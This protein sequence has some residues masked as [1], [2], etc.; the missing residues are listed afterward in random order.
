[1]TD[2]SGSMTFSYD[3]KGRLVEK[4]SIINRQSYTVSQSFTPGSRI[5]SVTYPTGRT[6]DYDRT[7]C[8]YIVDAVSTT[9]NGNTI[10]LANNLSYRPFGIANGINKGNG[11]MVNN[12]FDQSGRLTIANPGADKE[13]TYTYDTNGNLTSVSAPNTPWYNRT[14]TYDAL[15]RL[16]HAEGPYGIINYTYDA[17]GN[18]LT[19]AVNDQTETYNY[20]TGTNKLNEITNTEIIPYTHDAN[21]N[22]TGIGNKISTY[23]QNNKLIKVEEN[24]NILG[25]YTY[26]GL[27]QRVIKEVDSITT[28]FHYD[29]N[30]NIIAESDLDGTFTKEYL[31]RGKGRS[32]MVDAYSGEIYYFGND[33]LGTPQILTDS[34]NTV[35]WEGYYKPFGEV[36][37]NPNS[38]VVNNFR[39]L[40]QYYDQETGLH[41]NYHRYYD[42]RTGRYLTP[43]PS[44]SIQPRGTGVPYQGP[45]LFPYRFHTAQV[46]NL[47]LYCIGNPISLTDSTGLIITTLDAYMKQCWRHPAAKARCECVCAPVPYD[48][49][50]CVEQCMECFSSKKLLGKDLCICTC[51][52]AGHSEKDCK[53]RC[54]F[55]DCLE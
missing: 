51:K 15:N 46:L 33:R 54:K 25:K 34:T 13:R 44:H 31:Y 12:Q 23:N 55:I 3:N 38:S 20:V 5:S 30:G 14:H 35:V 11:G 32:A 24:G 53:R 39:F 2:P 8:T 27:G 26:N 19:K 29:F 52:A 17:V 37:I 42:P 47:Y 49:V 45:L 43:D 41:Y 18:R 4:T 16:N 10:P 22:I 6:I 7:T 50:K 21:G 36:D 48:Y 28:V 40:G 1:M 9:Y